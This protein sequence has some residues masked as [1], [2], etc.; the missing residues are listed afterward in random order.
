MAT[1]KSRRTWAPGDPDRDY[2]E[3]LK[4]EA[5]H[6]GLS[7]EA[8]T[9]QI[10]QKYGGLFEAA[11]K[12]AER[13]GVTVEDLYAQD[14]ALIEESSYPSDVCLQPFEVEL[15]AADALTAERREHVVGCRACSV[16]LEGA[17]PSPERQA[18]WAN[19]VREFAGAPARTEAQ[20]AIEW[21]FGWSNDVFAIGV[22]IGLFVTALGASTLD[23]RVVLTGCLMALVAFAVLVFGH[24]GRL[25][26]VPHAVRNVWVTSRGALLAAPAFAIVVFFASRWGPQERIAALQA[27]T[28]AAEQNLVEKTQS[29][30][31]LIEQYLTSVATTSVGTWQMTGVHPIVKDSMGPV[32]LSTNVREGNRAVYEASASGT[33]S[34][35][36]ADVQGDTGTIYLNKLEPDAVR[37]RILAGHVT[38]VTRT[39]ITIE[40]PQKKAH[41]LL[42]RGDLPQLKLNDRVIVVTDPTLKQ[43]TTATMLGTMR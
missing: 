6:D 36:L 32:V 43:V 19:E 37:A 21:R 11:E 38:D 24:G 28:A 15:F 16:L 18:A 17:I 41:E 14:R 30:Q 5:D 27:T 39:T 40:D 25:A 22:T 33:S 2:A 1:S 34:R 35:V 42:I 3:L 7:V 26:S 4:A 8:L 29:E 12:R 10:R 23:S 20:P 9:E 13:L 31:S